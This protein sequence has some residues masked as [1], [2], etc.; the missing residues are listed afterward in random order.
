M[1]VAISQAEAKLSDLR[2][3]TRRVDPN[4]KAKVDKSYELYSKEWRSRKRLVW[5][6]DL[7]LA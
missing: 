1:N 6:L 4:E 2:S 7:E 3:G 5:H